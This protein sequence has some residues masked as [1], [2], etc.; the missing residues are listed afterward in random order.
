MYVTESKH[1]VST[2]PVTDAS[3]KDITAFISFWSDTNPALWASAHWEASFGQAACQTWGENPYQTR[4]WSL[5][6]K[7]SVDAFQGIALKFLEECYLWGH[8]LRHIHFCSQNTPSLFPQRIL[9]PSS[10]WLCSHWACAG[11]EAW[12]L[13]V[14]GLLVG[15]HKIKAR[16]QPQF[17]PTLFFFVI[18]RDFQKWLYSSKIIV[19]CSMEI[20]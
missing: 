3:E 9:A 17:F 5:S 13:T 2:R 4:L 14:G 1:F 18:M 8:T 15:R 19:H 11:T 16:P 6:W 20:E 10:H 12:P 7:L